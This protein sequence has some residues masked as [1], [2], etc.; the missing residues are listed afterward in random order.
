LAAPA[1][2]DQTIPRL[3]QEMTMP[4]PLDANNPRR[5]LVRGTNWVGD[6]VMTLPALAALK[7]ACPRANITVLAKPWAA[8]VYA[9]C[10]GVRVHVFDSAGAHRGIKGMWRL[11]RELNSANHDWA[12]LFQNAL[13]AGLIAR[14]A[15]VKIRA[16]YATDGRGFLLSHPLP[17]HPRKKLVH[18]TSYYLEILH[19]LGLIPD[20]PPDSGVRPLIRLLPNDV[21][22][23]WRFLRDNHVEG[24][25]LGLAPGAAFGPAKCWPVERYIAAANELAGDGFGAVVLFGGKNEAEVCARV[26]QGINRL[27]VINLA[28]GC[29]L[30]Q[31]MALLGGLEL[32]ISNDSGLMHVAAA[33]GTPT[34]GVF[35]ST[36][37]T[38]TA[39][40]G[41][42]VKLVRKQV[43]CSPCL[44]PECPRDLECFT[45]IEPGEVAQAGREL[46]ASKSA[47]RLKPVV[48]LDRDGTINKDTDW[49]HQPDKLIMLPGAG[50]AI[51]RLN[52]AGFSVV[53]VT[54][55]SGIGRGIYGVSDYLATNQ[56]I[57]CRLARDGARVDRYYYCPHHPEKAEGDYL[58][59]CNC[60]KPG[61]GMLLQAANEMGLNLNRACL[62]G[63][64]YTDIASGNAVGAKGILLQEKAGPLPQS[65]D[66]SNKPAHVANTLGAAVDWILDHEKDVAG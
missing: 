30:G 43:E 13:Q 15:G 38:T 18:E 17:R 59:E 5:I 57:D 60:R 25:L 63:D 16:G 24:P 41:P 51:A 29:T 49:V 33:L 36:N 20:P 45:A 52:R 28:G 46:L 2:E 42:R 22:W 61:P 64:R 27:R 26:E 53:V 14:L 44:K 19:G 55:Q 58:V 31:A 47:A 62:V 39:P 10:P 9:C 37:P 23:A 35:G 32:F 7:K 4:K 12:V 34:I 56:E 11:A 3:A 6:A 48:F 21:A 66:E 8:P 1:V 54:N 65:L 50:K 40:L